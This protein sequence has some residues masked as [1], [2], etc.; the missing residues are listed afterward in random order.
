MAGGSGDGSDCGCGYW[1]YKTVESET[2]V[3]GYACVVSLLVDVF[4]CSGGFLGS[5]FG[6][7]VEL[8]EW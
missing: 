3:S 6:G 2:W 1:Y 7:V 5:G 4:G 8:V